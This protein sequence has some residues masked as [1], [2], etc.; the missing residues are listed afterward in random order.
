MPKNFYEVQAGSGKKKNQE[1]SLKRY[2]A[3]IK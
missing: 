2:K 1:I 3:Q